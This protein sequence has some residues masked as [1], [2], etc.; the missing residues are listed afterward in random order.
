MTSALLEQEILPR[1][2]GEALRELPDAASLQTQGRQILFTTDSFVVHPLEF[3]GG[4]IGDLA[5]HGTVND[6]AVA[7]GRAK[8]LSLGLILEEGLHISTLRR[9]L[10][11]L[12]DAAQ[13][14]GVELVTGDT[15][16]VP[17]GLCDGMYMNTAGIG[18]AMPG[19]DLGRK[20]VRA[21]DAILVSGPI[22]DHGMAVLA[23]REGIGVLSGTRSDAGSVLPLVA[24]LED[25]ASEVRFLRDPTRGGL[26]V[27]TNEV[28]QSSGLTLELDELCIP[29][30]PAT[31]SAA[32]LIGLDLLQVAC[33]GR[34]AAFVSE[35]VAEEVL[36]RWRALPEGSE[37][38][39]VGKVREG[40]GRVVLKTIIGGE[41][42]VDVAQGELLPRIC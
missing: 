26:S 41:R 13:G 4:N 7:G 29:T 20:K 12:R 18:E 16:V 21:G 33:E 9:V 25:I 10:D 24:S 34:V 40:G 42:T 36:K 2:G 15:K 17:R 38:A 32:E 14:V 19:F 30:S 31:R 8:W 11:S 23:A 6:L 1:I 39:R 37:A 5:V 3:P 22:G 28:A 35:A 27:L